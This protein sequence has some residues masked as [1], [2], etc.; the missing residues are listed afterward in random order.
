MTT[1]TT[2]TTVEPTATVSTTEREQRAQAA[3]TQ[4]RERV[5]V[6]GGRLDDITT[7][8]AALDAQVR[9]AEHRAQD[10]QAHATR[11][12][13][14]RAPPVHECL[15]WPARLPRHQPALK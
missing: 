13:P 12:P 8:L 11:Y 4:T 3:L 2:D 10:A 1:P 15:C 9:D 6:L 5:T 14:P 7:E